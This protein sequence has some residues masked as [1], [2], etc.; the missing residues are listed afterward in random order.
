MLRYINLQAMLY[1]HCL[2]N[3]VL[4]LEL[5]DLRSPDSAKTYRNLFHILN[6]QLPYKP[7]QLLY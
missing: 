5:S 1:F 6:K 4:I 2:P 3:V 7:V